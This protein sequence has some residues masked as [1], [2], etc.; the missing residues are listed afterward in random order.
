MS[1]Q[2]MRQPWMANMCS[3]SCIRVGSTFFISAGLLMVAGLALLAVPARAGNATGIARD[4]AQ[5]SKTDAVAGDA[6]VAASWRPDALLRRVAQR[7]DGDRSETKQALQNRGNSRVLQASQNGTGSPHNS[8]GAPIIGGPHEHK[9]P[10][11]RRRCSCACCVY[12]LVVVELLFHSI[13]LPLRAG[14]V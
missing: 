9:I 14:V 6:A 4:A 1:R 5:L 13:S 10:D 11:N 2:P 12:V 8:A 7:V 3:R